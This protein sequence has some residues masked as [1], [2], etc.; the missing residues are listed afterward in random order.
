MLRPLRDGRHRS[1]ILLPAAV[2]LAAALVA[3]CAVGGR[4]SGDDREPLAGTRLQQAE[5]HAQDARRQFDLEEF[6]KVL[7]QVGTLLD[8]YPEFEGN[9]QALGLAVTSAQ[10]L[11]DQARAL[12]L[13]RELRDLHPGSGELE[14]TLDRAARAALAERDTSSAVGFLQLSPT[15]VEA[16]GGGGRAALLRYLEG[17]APADGGPGLPA[18]GGGEGTDT[19]RRPLGLADSRRIGLLAPLT[20]RYAVLGNAFYEAARLAISHVDRDLGEKFL[21]KVA[22]TGGDPVQGALA[23]R[24]LCTEDKCLALVGALT[25]GPTVSAA[26][27]ADHLG[28]PFVSPTATNERIWELGEGVFQP[29]LTGDQEI[30]LM[31]TL[32]VDVLLKRRIAILAPDSP[33]GHRQAD[34]FG[35]EVSARGAEV[36]AQAFFP[37]QV[38]DFQAEILDLK[39]LRPEVVFVPASVD[40]MVMVGPQL[41]FY[42]LGA[43]VLGLG[44]WNDDRLI[45]S[46]SGTLERAVFPDDLAWFPAAWTADFQEAW[47]A[48]NY[49]GEAGS[50][51]LLAYQAVRN[52]L[53][54]IVQDRITGR[55]ALIEALGRK[56]SGNEDP[57]SGFGM[58]AT[59]IRVVEEGVIK[60]FPAGRFSAGLA[61][62]APAD[63]LRAAVADSLAGVPGPEGR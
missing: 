55:A 35:Q 26:L 63:S 57:E 17:T 11:G 2:L 50:I 58:L 12:T 10:R 25:S 46:T 9:D 13:A 15:A 48:A 34:L 5:R 6:G 23:A 54:T 31:A 29:N 28:V 27:V 45:A 40:Q 24:R 16:A 56:F 4:R 59:K 22:D 19:P 42:H 37:P 8:Y 61:S 62:P 3:G 38:T 53:E 14:P 18:A 43:L 44:S 7:D 51:A 33:D 41:D 36:V 1:R 60:P 20:G 30:R 52:L 32:A 49:P 39:K 21:L 47:D